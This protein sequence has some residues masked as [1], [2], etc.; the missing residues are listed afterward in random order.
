MVEKDLEDMKQKQH[1]ELISCSLEHDEIKTE[2]NK[3]VEMKEKEE[4]DLKEIENQFEKLK[5]LL[6][7]KNYASKKRDMNHT[8]LTMISSNNTTR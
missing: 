2:F 7:R 4:K 6:G 1:N 5:L 3:F 8:T